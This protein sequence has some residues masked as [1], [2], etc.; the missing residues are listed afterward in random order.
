LSFFWNAFSALSPRRQIGFGGIGAIPGV[1]IEIYCDLHGIIGDE[2][3]WLHYFVR[4][5]D[6]EYVR[7]MGEK[8]K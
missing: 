5:L 2:R 4:E 8:A 1:E 6:E 7:K 3:Y